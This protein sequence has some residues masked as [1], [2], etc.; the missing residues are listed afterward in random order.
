MTTM[1][2]RKYYT[3]ECKGCKRSRL[4][5]MCA[6]RNPTP[7]KRWSQL[8][9]FAKFRIMGASG[10]I[11]FLSYQSYITDQEKNLLRCAASYLD[12]VMTDYKANNDLSKSHFLEEYEK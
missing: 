8:R 6:S 10:T 1:D 7:A 5:C 3:D 11:R 2:F 12:Q 9:N 4:H